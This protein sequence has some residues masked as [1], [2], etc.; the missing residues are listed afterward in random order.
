MLAIRM[1]QRYSS[2]DEIER[3][4][5]RVSRKVASEGRNDVEYVV[6]TIAWARAW[7]ERNLVRCRIVRA[8]AEHL[9][10]YPGKKAPCDRIVL[11]AEP[12]DAA[13]RAA[14]P[15]CG[16]YRKLVVTVECGSA[17]HRVGFHGVR[18][19]ANLV[20]LFVDV[21]HDGRRCRWAALAH[22]APDVQR[23]SRAAVSTA[24]RERQRAARAG[25]EQRR[26]AKAER[27]A[28]R[29]RRALERAHL[30]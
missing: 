27:A 16:G 14:L 21:A 9:D 22:A 29:G 2:D 7:H 23:P 12:I 30:K 24:T 1:V 4:L 20:G 19:P 5:R 28:W 13:A 3:E 6:R 26:Q 10:D 15:M 17:M 8:R 11:W 18:D 25:A